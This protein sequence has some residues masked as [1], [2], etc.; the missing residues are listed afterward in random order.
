MFVVLLSKLYV[1]FVCLLL[2]FVLFLLLL[3]LRAR[4]NHNKIAPCGM[5]TVFLI[6][7]N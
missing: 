4:H 1:F 2:L 3:F 7:L 6:E 5:I